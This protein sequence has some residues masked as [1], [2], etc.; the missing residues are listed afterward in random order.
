MD[1]R[2]NGGREEEKKKKKKRKEE[3]EEEKKKKKKKETSDLGISFCDFPRNLFHS[4]RY[5]TWA[6][7]KSSSPCPA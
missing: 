7:E 3:E 2:A 4:L 6:M 1:S 5:P